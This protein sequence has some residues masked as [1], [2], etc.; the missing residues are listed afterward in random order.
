MSPAG[1]RRQHPR[2]T[3]MVGRCGNHPPE[4]VTTMKTPN[5]RDPNSLSL[6]PSKASTPS[7]RQSGNKPDFSGVS[8]T[9]STKPA[10]TQGTSAD[11]G[12]A[13]GR[14][15]TVRKGDTLSHIAK[16]HYGAASKWQQ[17]FDANRDQLDD[18]DLIRPGQV[19]RIP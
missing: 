6:K 1:S 4:R 17:L 7:G 18:P 10:R 19:L 3:P 15:Y 2:L 5:P 16:A 8:G 14:S 11:A 13:G 9:A 12:N